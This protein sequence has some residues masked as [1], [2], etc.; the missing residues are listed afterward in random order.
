MGLHMLV[1]ML[2]MLIFALATVSL[3]YILARLV[4][5]Y[6]AGIACS[7]PV[8]IG[9]GKLQCFIFYYLFNIRGKFVQ[10]YW[11]IYAIGIWVLLMGIFMGLR[12]RRDW[13]MDL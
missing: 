4:P 13:R 9:V 6:V 7:I 11:A 5:N 12:L 3:I 10:S 8:C 2:L 1:E